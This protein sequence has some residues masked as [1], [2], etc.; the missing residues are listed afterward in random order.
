MN[1]DADEDRAFEEQLLETVRVC[2][3]KRDRLRARAI[4]FESE[5]ADL[6]QKA[7]EQQQEAERLHEECR[8]KQLESEELNR[9][10]SATHMLHIKL[11]FE[12]KCLALRRNDPNTR[13]SWKDKE[14]SRH[15]CYSM[16]RGYAR[17]LGDAL[18]GNT[19]VTDLFLDVTNLLDSDNP[20]NP[21]RDVAEY[22]K[23]LVNFVSTSQVLQRVQTIY[24]HKDKHFYDHLYGAFLEVMGVSS[25]IEELAH[26]GRLPTEAFR[27]MMTS[28]VSLKRLELNNLNSCGVYTDPELADLGVAF[29]DNQSLECLHL[30]MQCGLAPILSTLPGHPTLQELKLCGYGNS[31]TMEHWNLMCHCICSLEALRHLTL[32]A[33]QFSGEMMQAFFNCLLPQGTADDLCAPITK[34][35]LEGCAFNTESTALFVEFLH[36]KID[37][38]S[39]LARLCCIRELCFVE[40]TGR[41]TT[42]W[43][44]GPLLVSLLLPFGPSDEQQGNGYQ[45]IG[46]QLSVLSLNVTNFEGFLEDLVDHAHEVRLD[47]LR[48]VELDVAHCH[49]LKTCILKMPCLR[50]LCL[51]KV[52][53]PSESSHIILNMLQQSETLQTF[54][55]EEHYNDKETGLL[56]DDAGVHLAEAYCAR[57]RSL[58]A[59]LE[60]EA[61]WGQPIP[62]DRAVQALYPALLQ[63][64]KQISKSRLVSL[65]SSLEKLG[66]FIGP[67]L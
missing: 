5:L 24:G 3:K 13:L 22:I 53:F 39:F 56:F 6:Y 43:L 20:N 9:E 64:T 48:L 67:A 16:I 44:T 17:P 65:L 41:D 57:N 52:W 60:R 55:V 33:F 35:S 27:T 15:P 62:S 46:S 66:D 54:V 45:T 51:A 32:A 63:A 18:R 61:E 34:L 10:Y 37:G 29:R 19:N 2:L 42:L 40:P 23:P 21:A 50:N 31:E 38:D 8:L 49:A 4:E 7:H 25:S 1:T 14:V 47:S 28:T 36:T 11:E 59:L 12:A 30:G 58:A 26:N